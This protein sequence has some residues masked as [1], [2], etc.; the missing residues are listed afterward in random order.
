MIPKRDT[1]LR[2]VLPSERKHFN[3]PKEL[4]NQQHNSNQLDLIAP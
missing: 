2:G 3:C 1:R 4:R